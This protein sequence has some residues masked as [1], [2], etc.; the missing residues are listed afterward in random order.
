MRCGSFTLEW[1]L[2]YHICYCRFKLCNYILLLRG[3][4]PLDNSLSLVV[5]RR[6]LLLILLRQSTYKCTCTPQV[7]A[8]IIKCWLLTNRNRAKVTEII[9]NVTLDP[10][11][12]FPW[13]FLVWRSISL[14]IRGVLR[15]FT[16]RPVWNRILRCRFSSNCFMIP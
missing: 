8:S 1:R 13:R 11:H 4:E 10:A 12:Y 9:I 6:L 3:L 2:Y 5:N 15:F 16:V 14:N 7:T